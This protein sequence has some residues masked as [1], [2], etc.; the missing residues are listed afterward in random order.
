MGKHVSKSKQVRFSVQDVLIVEVELQVGHTKGQL[1]EAAP[2]CSVFD[3][4]QPVG[5]Q[6]HEWLQQEDLLELKGDRGSRHR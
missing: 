1:I 4:L 5:A 3:G 2:A 6:S